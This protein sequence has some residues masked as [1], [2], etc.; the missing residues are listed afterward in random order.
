MGAEVGVLVGT[1]VGRAVGSPVGL[2]V[3]TWVG[4]PVGTEVGAGVGGRGH[5]PQTPPAS[6]PSC[7]R[8]KG[9]QKESTSAGYT[10]TKHM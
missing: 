5:K 3:G 8:L 9:M 4:T 1:L 7:T 2:L 10:S 6:S